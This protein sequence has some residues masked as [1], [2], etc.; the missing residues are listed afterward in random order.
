MKILF[1][2]DSPSSFASYI[3][4]HPDTLTMDLPHLRPS[5]THATCCGFGYPL[6]D[7]TTLRLP[8]CQSLVAD[9]SMIIYLMD[10]VGR[11]SRELKLLRET[12]NARHAFSLPVSVGMSSILQSCSW[13]IYNRR[14]PIGPPHSRKPPRH[15]QVLLQPGTSGPSIPPRLPHSAYCES[16]DPV[17][18]YEL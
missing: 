4:S 16:S 7:D 14:T 9:R 6:F 3:A 8:P 10:E 2:Y 12:C 11:L 18:G 15:N 5:P 1:S 17:N 13:L